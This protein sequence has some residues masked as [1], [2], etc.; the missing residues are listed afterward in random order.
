VP[1]W[2][3]PVTLQ[4]FAV[5]LLAAALGWRI[6]LATVALY[7]VEGL[8]GL[9]V[10]AG[11]AAGPA[12]LF[13]PTGGFILSWLLMAPIIGYATDRGASSRLL[14]LFGAMLLGDAVS[15]IIGFG[16]LATFLASVKSM[17]ADAAMAAAFKGAIAPF[18]I[19]DVL[20]MALAALSTLGLW[21]VL[22]RRT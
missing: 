6:G 7:I 13:G 8:A 9:P 15:F 2:P 12:Y 10:F 18:V 22:K 4:T 20:K 19:W 11:V 5:A 16:W 14:L 1:V 3:V 21:S 17:P